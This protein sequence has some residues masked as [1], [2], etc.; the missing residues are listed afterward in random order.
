MK[1]TTSNG[2]E[3]TISNVEENYQAIKIAGYANTWSA[4]ESL[5]CAEGEFY[6]FENDVRGDTT[7]CLVVRFA[8][9]QPIEIYETYDDILTCLIDEEILESDNNFVF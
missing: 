6:I 5:S 3:I 4:F 8:D 9:E 1:I 7:C 2:K